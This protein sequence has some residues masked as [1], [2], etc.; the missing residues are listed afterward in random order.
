MRYDGGM[1]SRA[2]KRKTPRVAAAT[3]NGGF[4]TNPVMWAPL[5]IAAFYSLAVVG[6]YMLYA[7]CD[8]TY[9]YLVYAK[10]Y[11]KGAGLTYNGVKVQG[12]T[13]MLWMWLI[14]LAGKLGAELPSAANALSVASGPLVLG[15]TFYAGQ[16]LGLGWRRSLAAPLLV[17][18]TGDFAFYMGV[19]LESILFTGML[20]WSVSYLLRDDPAK[21]A[22]SWSLPFVLAVTVFARPEGAMIAA[23][24]LGILYW[25]S[26]KWL[27]LARSAALVVILVFPVLSWAKAYYGAWLPNTFWAKSQAGLHNVGQ[28]LVYLEDFVA[29]MIVVFFLLTYHFLFRR[30]GIDRATKILGLIAGLWILNVTRQ[31]GDNMVGCR[32]MLP[33]VPLLYLLTVHLYRKLPGRAL[34]YGVIFVA[35][36]NTMIYGTGYV[37][38]STWRM[39]AQQQILGWQT[40]HEPRVAIGKFLKENLPPDA[41]IAVNAAGVVPYYA[42]LETIDM[43]GLNNAH[44]ASQGRR[45]FNLPYGHQVGDG[46]YVLAQQPEFILFST[47]RLGDPA[48]A[49]VS[50]QDILSNPEFLRLYEP[51]MLPESRQ[52]YFRVDIANKLFSRPNR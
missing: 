29:G 12:F 13:S 22:G 49:F 51:R 7:P 11:L 27:L 9:I 45:D 26:R 44:I 50:D 19:G 41:V 35:A 23:I 8:D 3:T 15:A 40:A 24:V 25:E 10:N 2:G 37:K 21:A 4:F 48:P 5:A 6:A 34:A 39:S 28:G 1:K 52:G 32:A 14:V 18:T 31:G 33:V 42:E 43:L 20:V 38:G 16:K 36:F 47:R 30:D 46:R 17:A